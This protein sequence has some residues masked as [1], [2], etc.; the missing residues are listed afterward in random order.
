M[1]MKR[2]TFIQSIKARVMYNW[3]LEII[4]I[5]NKTV[6]EVIEYEKY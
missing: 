1:G 5:L 3:N 6:I 4:P 2:Y